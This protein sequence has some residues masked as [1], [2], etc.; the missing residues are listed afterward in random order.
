VRRLPTIKQVPHRACK[1]PAVRDLRDDGNVSIGALFLGGV[2]PGAVMTLFLMGYVT[3][4]CAAAAWG[5][6]RRCA[7]TCSR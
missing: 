7:G 6:I 2:V 4:A 5:A 1:R 3:P